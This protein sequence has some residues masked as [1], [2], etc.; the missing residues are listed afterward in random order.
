MS[1]TANDGGRNVAL[2][3]E[4]GRLRA[5]GWDE[6]KILAALLV[7]AERRGL[8]E[9]EC[10]SIAHSIAR[11]PAGRKVDRPAGGWPSARH[12]LA[13]CRGFSVEAL[14][15]LGAVAKGREVHFPMR[16]GAGAIVG[17]RRRRADNQPFGPGKKALSHK[18]DHNGLIGPWPI[19]EGLVLLCEGE[20]D[21]AAALAAGHEA[22]VATPGAKPGRGV[23]ETLQT[24][25]TG[26]E[27]VL[28]PDPDTAGTMWRNMI[29][30][31]L[32]AA[33]CRVRYIAPLPGEDLDKR[34]QR[35]RADGRA[36]ALAR[37]VDGAFSWT[38][39]EQGDT[40]DA[41]ANNDDEASGRKRGRSAADILVRLAQGCELFHTPGGHDSESYA[42][43]TLADHSE[44][45]PIYSKAFRSWLARRYFDEQR[46]V[47]HAQAFQDALGV[48]AGQALYD[49]KEL[50]VHI[51]VAGGPG[52]IYLN[53]A[54]Q[55][56]RVVRV[57]RNGW[58]VLTES[59][60]RFLRRRGMMPL[61]VPEH[62]GA[63]DNLRTLVNFDDDGWTLVKA[64]L[65]AA[66]RPTGPYPVLALNGE[67]GSAKST[68]SRM[69]RG[70]VDP[71]TAPLRSEPRDARDLM[72]AATNAWIVAFDNLSSI[73]PWL[74]DALCRLATGG[75]FA[76]RELYS[77]DSERI[78]DAQRPV[79]L[80]GIEEIATR[81]D[82][83]DRSIHLS[84]PTIRSVS[85]R[86][87]K[88]LWEEYA[89]VRPRVLGALLTAL[90]TALREVSNV[91]LPEL[92]RMA[93]FALWS[94][95]GEAALG[96]AAGGFMSSYTGNR[97]L[98]NAGA[99]ETS[100]IGPALMSLVAA[101]GMWT[102]TARQLLAELEGRADEM[103]RRRRDW[104][105]TPRGLSGALRRLAPNLRAVE[106]GV[107]LDD[108]ST[109]RARKRLIR[110]EQGDAAPSEPSEPSD[111]SDRRR[112][113]DGRS[114]DGPANGPAVN[115]PAETARKS[116][117]LDHSDSSD[118]P[119]PCVSERVGTMAVPT[120]DSSEEVLID[121]DEPF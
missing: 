32:M 114:A 90:S 64:W 79:L 72:I 71:N 48:L 12:E 94:M 3:A 85:R 97:D 37:L 119:F 65:L 54:D 100:A 35:E 4:A 77:D 120:G 33:G 110:L 34:L 91:S 26:R 98:A 1:A 104:P 101:T 102:G 16:D 36:A 50:S 60:V 31:A 25:L 82:L 58:Q 93:D 106:I 96:I 115:R 95:A 13:G 28:A 73:H 52:Q 70:L 2:T 56:W 59:P 10:R 17:W 111:M 30:E 21:A 81:S 105:K 68:A 63:V 109:D 69:L 108:R 89:T 6:A 62:G 57:D 46:K 51:R 75:G 38:Q 87:E 43:I 74:S 14:R 45:W 23:V 47:P 118:G 121:G 92:P 53:L 15:K 112:N 78:F 11:K 24:V 107:L 8:P 83:A 103:T 19:P 18:G 49:G 88:D 55:Q 5:Q 41:D 80:N 29:G 67:Q 66:L 84:L 20:M 117:Q 99:I 116:C 22:V 86:V 61:P 76:T 44:T 113:D 9:S 27:I 39:Q 7:S 40:T 42:R